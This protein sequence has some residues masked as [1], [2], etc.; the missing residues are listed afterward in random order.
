MSGNCPGP[1]EKN[2]QRIVLAIRDLFNGRNNASGK[3]TCAVNAATTV[4]SVPNAGLLSN[5]ILFPTTANAAAELKNGTCYVSAV[6][7]G[8]FTVT[9]ANSAT[10]GR[11]FNY[12]I[13]G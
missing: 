12:F 3:F 10:T 1:S 2:L 6:G 9:H 5:P 7:L 13:N 8:S 4:V 11:T